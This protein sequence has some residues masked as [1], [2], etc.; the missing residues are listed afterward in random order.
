MIMVVHYDT[1]KDPEVHFGV[2]ESTEARILKQ[3]K[4]SYTITRAGSN[5]LLQYNTDLRQFKR[6]VWAR[7]PQISRAPLV[8]Y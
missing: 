3:L 8:C 1:E 7:Q 4:A 6:L 2:N 5:M